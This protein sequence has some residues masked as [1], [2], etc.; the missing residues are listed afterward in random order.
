MERSKGL[1]LI[2]VGLA[3]ALIVYQVGFSGNRNETS[4]TTSQKQGNSDTVNQ[5]RPARQQRQQANAENSDQTNRR[6][7]A[8][9]QG[10]N[11]TEPNPN[12]DRAQGRTN[13][14]D[15][16]RTQP[17]IQNTGLKIAIPE[18]IEKAQLQVIYSAYLELTG[19]RTMRGGRPTG[20]GGFGGAGGMMGGDMGGFGGA[21]GMMG[22]GMMDM[23]EE[24]MQDMMNQMGGM[25]GGRG[26]FGG[27]GRGGMD[28]QQQMMDMQDMGMNDMQMNIDENDQVQY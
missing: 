10:E 7:G 4:D 14:R 20:R 22:G 15:R 9:P 3:A 6:F 17:T 8:T 18:D 25:M 11:T 27:G 5:D 1:I 26:G 13:T 28:M 19:G 2:V 21:G 16:N 23:T 12:A 24:D